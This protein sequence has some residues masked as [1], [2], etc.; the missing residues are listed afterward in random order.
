MD[1]NME[2]KSKYGQNYKY[3]LQQ[4]LKFEKNFACGAISKQKNILKNWLLKH[5]Y[6]FLI[7]LKDLKYYIQKILH[8]DF[9]VLISEKKNLRPLAF[10][11][12]FK[13]KKGH[14]IMLDDENND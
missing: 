6:S 12:Y 1:I 13:L 5:F 8:F 11:R 4:S 10:E 3:I 14:D 2:I 7:D 9:D